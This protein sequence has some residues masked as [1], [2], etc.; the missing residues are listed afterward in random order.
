E[1]ECQ[2]TLCK[3][4]A[5]LGL[6]AA[7]LFTMTGG[8]ASAA[9]CMFRRER[10]VVNPLV[11]TTMTEG[12]LAGVLAHEVAHLMLAHPR[13][14][15]MHAFVRDLCLL[16]ALSVSLRFDEVW[17][18]ALILSGACLLILFLQ[19]YHF[20][21]MELQADAVVAVIGFGREV[22]A[23]MLSL[24]TQHFRQKIQKSVPGIQE[25]RLEDILA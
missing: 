23:A 25:Q 8:I 22:A 7:R 13:L 11:M 9:Y 16:G 14:V 5:Q 18:M 17:L 4:A 21:L 2:A 24:A 10:I 1:Q 19:L 3:L 12:E 6:R 15:F 20:R